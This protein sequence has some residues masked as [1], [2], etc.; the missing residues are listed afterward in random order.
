M[1][2]KGFPAHAL[3]ATAHRHNPC[4]VLEW[5]YGHAPH[6]LTVQGGGGSKQARA[7]PASN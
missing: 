7:P 6:S 1:G 2:L 5:T 4:V 3:A